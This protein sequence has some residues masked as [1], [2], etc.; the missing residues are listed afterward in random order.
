MLNLQVKPTAAVQARKTYASAKNSRFVN[1]ASNIRT[2]EQRWHDTYN[3]LPHN[4]QLLVT[5]ALKQAVSEFRR[6]NPQLRRWEDLL[7]AEAK[8]VMLSQIRID[9]TMQRQLDI[10]WVLRLL[11]HFAAT[12]VVPIQ[13]YRPTTTSTEY[14]AWDGQHTS[15]L[16]WLIATQLFEADPKDVIVPVNVYHSTLKSEMRGN[17]I[18]L[19]SDEG[20]KS[21]DLID[22]F[23]QQVFGASIDGSTNPLWQTALAKQQI[24]QRYDLFATAKKFGDEHMPGA[25]TRLQEINKLDVDTLDWVCAYLQLSTAGQ[26]AVGEK[27]MVMISHYFNRC[28]IDNVTVDAAYIQTLHTVLDQL[29]GADF[30]PQGAFWE[31]ARVAYHNWYSTNSNSYTLGR[32]NKEPVHGFPFLIAQLNK[33]LPLP[34]PR[35]DSN[36]NFWPAAQ[37]LF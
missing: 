25:I 12:M 32:F 4:Q 33:S 6:R 26:R 29:F 5:H 30:D 22:I 20:K 27:E 24:L 9:G 15:V 17:F 21:L 36:S 34:T 18:A 13:V 10:F 28:R 16:L 23:E 8:Q 31:Q 2:I 1:T 3:S 37:D 35:N 11:N 14:L 7:L 19:N